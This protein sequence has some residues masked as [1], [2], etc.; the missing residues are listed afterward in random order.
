MLPEV[1]RNSLASDIYE[2]QTRSRRPDVAFRE[3]TPDASATS[4]GSP[5]A[6]DK[7]E[8]SKILRV[9]AHA[10]GPALVSTAR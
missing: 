5:G 8:K 4:E 3:F 2:G 9:A 6:Q 7:L 1:E 10:T